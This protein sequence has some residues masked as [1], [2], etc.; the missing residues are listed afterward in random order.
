ME[1]FRTNFGAEKGL[2][3]EFGRESHCKPANLFKAQTAVSRRSD[4]IKM[5]QLIGILNGW[6]SVGGE[7]EGAL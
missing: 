6:V 2:A 3:S 1:L 4:G 5:V 7:R